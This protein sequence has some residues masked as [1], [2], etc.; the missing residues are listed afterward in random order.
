MT[1]FGAA[2]G[3]VAG[4]LLRVELRTVNHRY[5]NPSLKLPSDLAPLEGQIRER[6]RRDFE[7]GHLS[8]SLR[9]VE[10]ARADGALRLNIERARE[11]MARL[12]ELQT[13]VGL[14]GE[15]SVELLARQP[16][17]LT[18]GEAASADATWPEVL[19]VLADAIADCRA[20]RRREGETLAVELR[21]RLEQLDALGEKVEE[22]APE[23]L[24]R[25]RDR[26]RAAISQLLDGRVVDESRLMQELAF[27]AERLDI[28]EELVRLRAH[29]DA[30]RQTLQLDG[31]IGK[32]LGF[33]SQ[34]LGREVNTIGSKANDTAIAHWVIDM[35]EEL[36]RFREQVENLE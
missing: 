35:K 15:I 5:F 10:M 6:L 9:W 23:R 11:A 14:S 24:S 28:R 31:P 20:M 16:E 1:G 8:V 17:V 30:A 2:E 19:A 7:R 12:R 29:L 13:A 34:E 27:Q 18:V 26:L 3:E 36:E 33:L 32:R 21:Q 4:G 25:Q 22:R